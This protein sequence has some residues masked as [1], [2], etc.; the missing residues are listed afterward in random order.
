MSSRPG[1][2]GFHRDLVI[3][4]KG[5]EGERERGR[6]GQGG[7]EGGSEPGVLGGG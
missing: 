3:R 5:R 6:E 4:K 7:R 1:H 2:P